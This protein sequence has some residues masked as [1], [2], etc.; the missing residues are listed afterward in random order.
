[1]SVHVAIFKSPAFETELGRVVA[2]CARL[3]MDWSIT[4]STLETEAPDFA[5]GFLPPGERRVP[6][7][8]LRAL[9]NKAERTPLLLITPERLTHPTLWLEDSL[10]VLMGDSPSEQRIASRLRMLDAA[11]SSHEKPGCFLRELRR[12]RFFAATFANHD[13]EVEPRM[14]ERGDEW[15]ALMPRRSDDS[16]SVAMSRHSMTPGSGPCGVLR[17]NVRNGMF[18]GIVDPTWGSLTLAS[19]RR[20]PTVYRFGQRASETVGSLRA[21]SGDVLVA[22]SSLADPV[23]ERAAWA[24]ALSDGAGAVL[25]LLESS[26]RDGEPV[27]GAVLEIL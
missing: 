12:P 26:C 8:I 19:P 16:S 23:L 20:A 15:I 11:S 13:G 3:G 7:A 10:L 24:E 18:L 17:L 27:Q 9:A 4:E 25:E 22:L 21:T 14:M 5:V 6:R 2:A 1:M